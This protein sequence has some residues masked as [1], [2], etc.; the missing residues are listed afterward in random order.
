MKESWADETT[1]DF[2]LALPPE[3]SNSNGSTRERSRYGGLWLKLDVEEKRTQ[4]CG[5]HRLRCTCDPVVESHLNLGTVDILVLVSGEH[6]LVAFEASPE[7]DVLVLF[8]PGACDS[9]RYG[10]PSSFA[11]YAVGY[12][13]IR[14]A[15]LSESMTWLGGRQPCRR[16]GATRDP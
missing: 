8:K 16:R 9:H 10:I 11:V 5:P 13:T 6:S 7:Q 1:R 12:D 2:L 3:D 14:V 4:G 15:D